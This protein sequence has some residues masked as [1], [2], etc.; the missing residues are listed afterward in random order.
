MENN[1]P[2]GFGTSVYDSLFEAAP[3]KLQIRYSHSNK[4][5]P[6]DRA[7]IKA[8]HPVLKKG[9]VSRWK[10][11]DLKPLTVRLL[12]ILNPDISVLIQI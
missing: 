7:C 3:V 11:K 1:Y 2:V 4:G 5:C 6:Y 10:S 12:N 9:E 8:F